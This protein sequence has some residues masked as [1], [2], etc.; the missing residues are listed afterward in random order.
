MR[1]KLSNLKIE[2]S[3]LQNNRN[4]GSKLQLNLKYMWTKERKKRRKENAGSLLFCMHRKEK[5]TETC[6]VEKAGEKSERASEH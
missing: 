2:R 4:N 3:N 5:R 1:S 6:V